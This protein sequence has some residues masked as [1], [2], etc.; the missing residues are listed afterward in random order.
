MVR[1]LKGHVFQANDGRRGVKIPDLDSLAAPNA[2][3]CNPDIIES[4][5][6]RKTIDAIAPGEETDIWTY[7]RIGRGQ[8]KGGVCKI[9]VDKLG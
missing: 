7:G 4:Y 8:L 3:R 5:P 9:K 1:L 2:A 6:L